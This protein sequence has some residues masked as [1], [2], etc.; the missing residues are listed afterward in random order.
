MPLDYNLA[1][2]ILPIEILPYF[3]LI[4]VVKQAERIDLY[5]D[6]CNTP[7]KQP[8]TYLSKGFSDERTIQDFPLRGKA[9]FLHVRKRKWQEIETG[10]IVTNS[11]ELAHQG[12]H[13][14]SEFASFLKAAH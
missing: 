1:S 9:V 6:E 3:K 12:T 5:L 10:H 13:L 11:Y 4:Q 14:T 7:P 8:Y 2:L